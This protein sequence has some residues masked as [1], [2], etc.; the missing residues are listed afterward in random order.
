M[1]IRKKEKK[2]Y[3]L[4]LNRLQYLDQKMKPNNTLSKW[5]F[6]EF[7]NI[8]QVAMAFVPFLIY[9]FNLKLTNAI[10]CQN[11]LVCQ[12]HETLLGCPHTTSHQANWRHPKHRLFLTCMANI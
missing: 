2:N 6:H 11:S 3:L 5:Y 12:K 1:K 8:P 9:E 10:L 4:T 7:L